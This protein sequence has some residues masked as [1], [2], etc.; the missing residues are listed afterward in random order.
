VL[1]QVIS[2]ALLLTTLVAAVGPRA[3]AAQPARRGPPAVQTR[4][5]APVADRAVPRSLV[6]A[7]FAARRLSLSTQNPPPA[8]QPVEPM[9]AVTGNQPQVTADSSLTQKWWFWAAMGTL[10]VGSAVLLLA[11]VRPSEAP[12]TR[13]GNMEAFR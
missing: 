8:P 4:T 13:L 6:L 3:A 2:R 11:A 5:S 7:T 1:G 9:H 12:S 10:A